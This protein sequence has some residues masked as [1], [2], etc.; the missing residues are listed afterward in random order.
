MFKYVMFFVY[1]KIVPENSLIRMCAPAGI[2]WRK[3]PKR[4][5]CQHALVCILLAG[6]E[7]I[8][9]GMG[10]STVCLFLRAGPQSIY[11]WECV[12]VGSSLTFYV[13]DFH[14]RIDTPLI[15]Y[16]SNDASE[17]VAGRVQS[18]KLIP[19]LLCGCRKRRRP[20]FYCR[21]FGAKWSG[22][23]GCKY[24]LPREMISCGDVL[25]HSHP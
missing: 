5:C 25:C 15:S 1:F 7:W 24:E 13:I 4:N 23:D 16:L 2:V 22:R 21:S 14:R 18:Q 19:Q 11:I 9:C 20:K 17:W 12:F 8:S 10:S 6:G 3:T